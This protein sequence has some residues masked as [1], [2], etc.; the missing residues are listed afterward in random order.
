[1][2]EITI[3]EFAD[4]INTPIEKLQQQLDKIG[5]K[6]TGDDIISDDEKEILL[7]Y[8]QKERG[9]PE[10]YIITLKRK[11][12]SQI[13][14]SVTNQG[15]NKSQSKTVN[16]EHRKR[17]TYAKR[18][19]LIDNEEITKKNA[20]EASKDQEA[21]A[22]IATEEIIP[23]QET[24]EQSNDQAEQV[25]VDTP[26]NIVATPDDTKVEPAKP[27]ASE[28]QADAK[29]DRKKLHV[30]PAKSGRRK[31]SRRAKPSTANPIGTRHRFEK[32]TAP[33]VHEVD[34]PESISVAELA[35]RMS[36]KSSE[37]IKIMMDLGSIATINQT[38]DQDTA[39]I[40][41][42]EMGHKA[43]ILKENALEEEI[44]RPMQQGETIVRAPIVT[45][46]GHV[47][48]GKTSLLDYIR[49]TK[50]ASN[51]TGGITQ[52]IGAY[53]VH[54]KQ[55]DITFL[56][57]PGH[58]A[59]TAMRARGA[60]VTDI[61][62]IV[63]AADDGIMPQ[64]KESI[65]HAQ[66]AN[67]PIIIAVNKIDKEH[68]DLER[69]RQD[70][71]QCDV[72]SEEWGGQTIFNH[73]SA[74]T[75]EG[76]DSLLDNII[77]QAEIME[78]KAVETGPATGTIIESRLDRGRGPVS[79][80]LLQN[81]ALAKGDAVLC[82]HEYG[83]V[84]IMVNEHNQE[85]T[86]ATP[87][88]PVEVFGLSGITEVGSEIVVVE[89]EKKAREV[90]LFR[91]GKYREIKIAT[92]QANK[93]DGH[94]SQMQA[95]GTSSLNLVIK[96]DVKGSIE[97]LLNVLTTIKNEE[98]SPTVVHSGV[99]GI[100]ISDINLAQ[101]SN[102]IVIG[103]NVR[104]DANAKKTALTE[105]VDLR[106]YSIIY[107]FIDD[108]NKAVDGMLSQET[109][110]QIIGVAE[111]QEVFKSP[112]LGDIAGCIVTSGYIKRNYPIRV[113][114]DDVVIYEGE[115]ESLRRFK[116]NANEV[117]SGIECGIGVKNYNNVK[118]GDHI[119]VFERIEQS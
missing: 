89:N 37:V 110:E 87:S 59:F 101:A 91:Q 97:A 1:M 98:V 114:R 40:V 50:V 60:Q 58:Q 46:M 94:I 28:N 76:I 93:Q 119:E 11:E 31:K 48:H 4:K 36:V 108:L 6:K 86:Q 74:K 18:G 55:G 68:T 54:T 85:I 63:V 107:D 20:A 78:L 9:Q 25:V 2:S 21:T 92:Q 29:H 104:A 22:S 64:T 103:F 5:L 17:R 75:G 16:V 10:K 96:A 39:V 52:H 67:V 33:I 24:I 99:G 7:N 113:L 12:I 32:P 51:E 72:I 34:I 66:A 100:N 3:N 82:G 109:H 70:L 53:K 65:K 47:D 49:K 45:I 43:N 111:V 44:I 56:D 116:D 13:K 30:N 42:E 15:K 69:I 102:A 26:E 61:A 105:E 83:R 23:P 73:V 79:T 81:G 8:L 88:T 112:K 115:L 90:A 84:R 77:L 80:V 106:Y 35:Q 57:T 14:V 41:V 117:K 71:S 95:E 62:V 118:I 27:Q 19:F 38:I